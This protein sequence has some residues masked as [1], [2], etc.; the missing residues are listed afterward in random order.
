V[1]DLLYFIV[2]GERV[3]GDYRELQVM[4]I[5]TAFRITDFEELGLYVS[6]GG[7]VLFTTSGSK[8]WLPRLLQAGICVPYVF[9]FVSC[10]LDPE[11]CKVDEGW[12]QASQ[13]R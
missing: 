9:F 8:N 10:Q 4:G 3:P 11:A 7:Y 5:G 13:V 1:Y 2:G 12:G 6:Y